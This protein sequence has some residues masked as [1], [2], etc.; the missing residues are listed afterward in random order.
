MLTLYLDAPV[1]LP[2]N[3]DATRGLVSDTSSV[4]AGELTNEQVNGIE[5]TSVA[6]KIFKTLYP[7]NENQEAR[8]ISRILPFDLGLKLRVS[9]GE[10]YLRQYSPGT[11]LGQGS[12]QPLNEAILLFRDAF[13][14]SPS[15]THVQVALARCL[16]LR[17]GHLYLIEDLEECLQ[18]IVNAVNASANTDSKKGSIILLWTDIPHFILLQN[19]ALVLGQRYRAFRNHQDILDCI[20]CHKES[21]SLINSQHPLSSEES[22]HVASAQVHLVNA[23]LILSRRE[24]F[25][26]LE[27]AVNLA[28]SAHTHF[29]NNPGIFFT[30]HAFESVDNR[31][32]ISSLADA[33]TEWFSQSSEIQHLDEAITL[34]TPLTQVNT[35]FTALMG[36]GEAITKSRNHNNARDFLVPYIP[37]SLQLAVMLSMRY[38]ITTSS[39]DL[40]SG[41][42][43][44]GIATFGLNTSPSFY[45][46][47]RGSNYTNVIAALRALAVISHC[48]PTATDTEH[49]GIEGYQTALHNFCNVCVSLIPCVAYVGLGLLQRLSLLRLT[50][51]AASDACTVAVSIGK[52][53]TA[54]EF[55]ERGRAQ[56]WT[57]HLRVRSDFSGLPNSLQ[58][59]LEKTA[60]ELVV[61]PVTSY[62]SAGS[63]RETKSSV[64]EEAEQYRRKLAYRFFGYVDEARRYRGFSNF[65]QDRTYSELSFAAKEGPVVLLIAAASMTCA[66][67][68]PGYKVAPCQIVFDKAKVNMVKLI[69]LT[70]KLGYQTG[71]T[72]NNVSRLK[73]VIKSGV[74]K[75]TSEDRDFLEV[76]SWLYE[77]IVK[78]VLNNLKLTKKQG[79]QRPRLWWCPTGIFGFLPI[80]AAGTYTPITRAEDVS[81]YVVSSYT[82]TLEALISVRKHF[83]VLKRSQPR[84]LLIASPDVDG[85]LSLSDTQEEVETA[86]KLIPPG[87]PLG[88]VHI[89]SSSSSMS[90]C[91][92]HFPEANI[93]HLACHGIQDEN[94]P[95]R[96]SFL[97]GPI[98]MACQTATGDVSHPDQSVHLAAAMLFMGFRSV[99]AT[100]WSMD[101][102]HGPRLS[103][104]IYK[105]LFQSGRSFSSNPDDI[106]FVIDGF[107]QELRQE[108]CSVRAWVTFMHFGM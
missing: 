30:D 28:R 73:P 66:L 1:I 75:Q 80:H 31:R 11:I 61:L 98:L 2:P 82:P 37:Y 54:V 96:S 72:I 70:Q 55:L 60:S 69:E 76:L 41:A 62:Y 63:A 25:P 26:D 92:S 102:S 45:L 56:L 81:D 23:L 77:Y 32:A 107:R 101:D 105:T 67:V 50:E 86:A 15:S 48:V 89:L 99:V 83:Q 51:G 78:P 36:V 71:P 97:L 27:G 39:Q 4:L 16:Y 44:L 93:V 14:V 43:C 53:P 79:R 33:L 29:T 57:Q 65:L 3:D 90:Q 87:L 108:K 85:Q 104:R 12:I 58:L 24:K 88:D 91:I 7:A 10:R 94:D 59:K 19:K 35:G 100:M 13:H 6:A 47:E 74:P 38:R 52:T 34:L 20:S 49:G 9:S 21:L 42:I 8:E 46:R 5:K 18:L 64:T 84:V 22:L 95:L 106:P 103:A 17:F 40:S 68:I